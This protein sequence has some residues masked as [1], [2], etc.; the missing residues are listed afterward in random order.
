MEKHLLSL[1]LS[2]IGSGTILA[3]KCNLLRG[4][5][6]CLRGDINGIV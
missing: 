2:L 3:F 4:A 6:T 1:S 5:T